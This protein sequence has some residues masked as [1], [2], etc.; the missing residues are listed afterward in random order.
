MTGQAFGEQRLAD[1]LTEGA[2][3]FGWADRPRRRRE[4]DW[5]VGYGVASSVYP[6][7]RQ[8]TSTA[9]IRYED[10]KLE[11]IFGDEWRQWSTGTW[12]VIPKRLNIGKL[13]DTAW[14]AHQSLIRNGELYITVYLVACAIW[15]W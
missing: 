1:C 13:T 10:A 2:R 9:A 12:A 8:A 3:R 6:T 5:L 7:M 11:R 4:G 14:S 15:L